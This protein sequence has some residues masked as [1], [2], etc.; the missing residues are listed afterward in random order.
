MKS[1][2]NVEII[3]KILDYFNLERL[4]WQLTEINMI[5]LKY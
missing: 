5:K 3:I 2:N 4:P 1:E